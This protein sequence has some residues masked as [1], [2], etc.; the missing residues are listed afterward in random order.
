M[1]APN[2]FSPVPGSTPCSIHLHGSGQTLCGRC[3]V[4]ACVCVYM[5]VFVLNGILIVIGELDNLCV[6]R[7]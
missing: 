5:C 1:L 2:Q 3:C 4:R 7:S 6:E